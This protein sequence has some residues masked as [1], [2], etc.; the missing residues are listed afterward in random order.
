MLAKQENFACYL[1]RESKDVPQIARQGWEESKRNGSDLVIF[2]TAGR[3]QIDDDLVDELESLKKEINPHEIL[4]VADAALGQE[5][6]NVAKTF[7]VLPRADHWRRH[8]SNTKKYYRRMIGIMDPL[9]M[10]VTQLELVVDEQAST[11][12][13]P[14]FLTKTQESKVSSFAQIP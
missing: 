6:V 9:D 1:N 2:D 14:S 10:S 8:L 4:L 11:L 5:A 12:P 7:H 13:P 3:L